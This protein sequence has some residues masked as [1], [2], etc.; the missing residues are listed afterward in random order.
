MLECEQVFVYPQVE[1]LLP[2]KLWEAVSVEDLP[3]TQN[4]VRE[5][6]ELEEDDQLP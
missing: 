3:H 4:F 2:L 6:C 5:C 1:Q